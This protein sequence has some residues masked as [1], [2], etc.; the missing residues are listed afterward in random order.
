M[1]KQQGFTLI[2]L[3]VVIVILGILAATALPKFLDVQSQAKVAA[4]TGAE[5]AINSAANL[6]HAAQLVAGV[7]SNV[8]VTLGGQ[9][10]TMANG[11]P[12]A[13]PAGILFAAGIA[14]IT[15]VSNDWYVTGGNVVRLKNN[16][17]STCQVTYTVAT[18][19]VGPIVTLASNPP[20][21]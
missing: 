5:G 11:Y 14:D 13:G 21:C 16:P 4:I 10:I 19:S 20:A 15:G 6:A 7:G 18:G 17:L 1:R 2:E 3:I 12:D 8:S 9:T